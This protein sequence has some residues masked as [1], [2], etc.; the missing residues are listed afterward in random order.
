MR[1]RADERTG[2]RRRLQ[3]LAART[4]RVE[5]GRRAG[6][7]PFVGGLG[8]TQARRGGRGLASEHAQW[9]RGSHWRWLAIWSGGLAFVSAVELA[10]AFVWKSA[11]AWSWWR[12]CSQAPPARQ[13]GR[14]SSSRHPLS[15]CGLF[16]SLSLSHSRS[17][18]KR[19][20]RPFVWPT[21]VRLAA[22][23]VA[24]VLFAPIISPYS[25]S[26]HIPL[27]ENIY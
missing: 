22:S 20:Q 5:R 4:R 26:D 23:H 1:I 12:T 17:R 13:R 24:C 25:R 21:S 11:L 2:P 19:A 15:L 27:A 3:R 18:E 9:R 7:V 10:S 16:G 6:S 14:W 8:D